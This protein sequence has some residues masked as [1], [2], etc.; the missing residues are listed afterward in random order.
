MRNVLMV[1]L[2]VSTLSLIGSSETYAQSPKQHSLQMA[3]QGGLSHVNV[4]RAENV[5]QVGKWFPRIQAVVMYQGSRE[6]RLNFWAAPVRMLVSTQIA[7]DGDVTYV[8]N[9]GRRG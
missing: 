9:R 5:A 3:R 2:A 1:L 7:R 4:G 6:H 8:T